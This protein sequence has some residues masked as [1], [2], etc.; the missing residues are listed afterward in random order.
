VDIVKLIV[1]GDDETVKESEKLFTKLV[2]I[3]FS[4]KGLA[5]SRY[6]PC[7]KFMANC[8]ESFV[9]KLNF[10]C[11]HFVETPSNTFD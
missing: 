11:C 9:E 7:G 1:R 6:V 4:K 5:P 2:F 8:P 3:S 10:T